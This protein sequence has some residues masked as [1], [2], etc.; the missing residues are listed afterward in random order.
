MAEAAAWMVSHPNHRASDQPK[1]EQEQLLRKRQETVH[2][3][4]RAAV[5]PSAAAQIPEFPMSLC[6]AQKSPPALPPPARAGCRS[7]PAPDFHRRRS[8]SRP[9]ESSCGSW[10]NTLYCFAGTTRTLPS[11]DPVERCALLRC[12]NP[13]SVWRPLDPRLLLFAI[14]ARRERLPAPPSTGKSAG[15]TVWCLVDSLRSA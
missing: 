6:P 1:A 5:Q 3:L 9:R 2:C 13:N 12:E 8:A 10:S 15:M 11:A 14:P 4:R 7:A